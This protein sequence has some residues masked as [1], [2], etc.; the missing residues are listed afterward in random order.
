MRYA[1]PTSPLA[2]TFNLGKTTTTDSAPTPSSSR[3]VVLLSGEN[4]LLE[5]TAT[6]SATCAEWVD[7]L[8]LLL[9]GGGGGGGRQQ[10]GG[11][12]TTR[13]SR[14]MIEAL[15]ETMLTVKLLDITGERIELREH[16]V[17]P[18]PPPLT[19]DFFYSNEF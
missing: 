9:P 11:G 16:G 4:V 13:E 19:V 2:K 17:R 10:G 15:T 14:E 7:G 6:S 3:T 5:M 12:V 8:S 1:G 18:P